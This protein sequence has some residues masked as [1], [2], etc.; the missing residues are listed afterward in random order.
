M[1]TIPDIVSPA[2][3]YCE[4]LTPWWRFPVTPKRELARGH[5]LGPGSQ[6][7]C[8]VPRPALGCSRLCPA[9]L[10]PAP[11]EPW[12]AARG[13]QG[14][15]IGTTWKHI[16][17]ELGW[18]PAALAWLGVQPIFR[19]CQLLPGFHSGCSL[20]RVQLGSAQ[21]CGQGSPEGDEHM[22]RQGPPP[23]HTALLAQVDPH[24]LLAWARQGFRG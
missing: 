14:L 3:I 5:I 13:E 22:R 19:D 2:G 1:R 18:K 20:A 12:G 10:L 8:C 21:S 9:W 4:L 24:M 11:A 6:G 15:Q 23:T 17:N 16:C 7:G